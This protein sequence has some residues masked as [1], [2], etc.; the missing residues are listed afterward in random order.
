MQISKKRSKINFKS[1]L[2]HAIFLALASNFMDVDTIIPSMLVKAGGNS[3]HLGF[4]T[5][6]MLGGSSVMQLVFAPMLS[7]KPYKLKHLLLGI[8]LRVAALLLMSVMFI[9]SG[10]ISGNTTIIL[11]F[12]LISIFSFSGSYSGISYTDILGKS[13]RSESRKLFFSSKEIVISVGILVSAF[14]VRHILPLYNYPNNYA[15]L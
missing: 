1:F 3:I 4:L 12:I 13:I 14:A 9:F 7:K 2:W 15:I 11:I 8:N 6:I 10:N 5:A